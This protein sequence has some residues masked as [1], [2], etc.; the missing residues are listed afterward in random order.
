M[1]SSPS[2]AVGKRRKKGP[3]WPPLIDRLEV[4]W[5]RAR[6]EHDAP[7]PEVD[8]RL[9]DLFPVWTTEA[10][11][12]RGGRRCAW[13]QVRTLHRPFRSAQPSQCGVVERSGISIV[14]SSVDVVPDGTGPNLVQRARACG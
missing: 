10:T 4:N 2:S 12:E 13:S 11:D 6:R 14:R 7:V 8:Q 5:F 1:G 3:A 9:T